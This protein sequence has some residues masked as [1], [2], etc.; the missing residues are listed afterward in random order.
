MKRKGICFL[1]YHCFNFS[2]GNQCLKYC[3]QISTLFKSGLL[4]LTGQ[5]YCKKSRSAKVKY[6]II[7]LILRNCLVDQYKSLYFGEHFRPSLIL[8]SRNWILARIHSQGWLL[9]L[10]NY[11]KRWEWYIVTNSLAYNNFIRKTFY[12]TGP[13]F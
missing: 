12:C 4:H 8:A 13:N 11:V 9:A 1:V 2:T 10:A 6:G 7:N 3:I 5:P